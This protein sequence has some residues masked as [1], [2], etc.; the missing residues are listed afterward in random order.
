MSPALFT[1]EKECY[2]VLFLQFFRKGFS[3]AERTPAWWVERALPMAAVATRISTFGHG[4]PLFYFR[5]W[6]NTSVWVHLTVETGKTG[7]SAVERLFS[8]KKLGVGL[9]GVDQ[10][11]RW[12]SA[13]GSAA[14]TWAQN[15]RLR[16]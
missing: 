14:D 5:L 8:G 16:S 12:W 11:Q 1:P 2:S 15:A 10:P 3:R 4:L 6:R 7:D 9:A 13:Q